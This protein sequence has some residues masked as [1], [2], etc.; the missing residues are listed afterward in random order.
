MATGHSNTLSHNN[1]FPVFDGKCPIYPSIV[2][3]YITFLKSYRSLS[4]FE[5]VIY[6]IGERYTEVSLSVLRGWLNASHES[7][8]V[9]SALFSASDKGGGNNPDMIDFNGGVLY[10]G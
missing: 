9:A 3:K 7:E 8:G 5:R 6:S 10:G 1:I 2:V 4:L